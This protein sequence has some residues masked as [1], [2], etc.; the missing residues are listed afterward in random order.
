MTCKY[1]GNKTQHGVDICTKCYAK[2]KLIRKIQSMLQTTKEERNK[3]EI[4]K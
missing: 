2:R 3:R 4:K 1:C